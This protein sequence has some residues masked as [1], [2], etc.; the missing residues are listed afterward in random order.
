[1]IFFGQY[2]YIAVC[3][4][5]ITPVEMFS[6][7]LNGCHT[8]L[9]PHYE[10]L[11][12]SI[13]PKRFSCISCANV[14]IILFPASRQEHNAVQVALPSAPPPSHSQRAIWSYTD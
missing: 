14:H 8:T 12:L 13:L 6:L 5:A 7:C 11:Q 3:N 10:L 2:T 4:A 1:M 9:P